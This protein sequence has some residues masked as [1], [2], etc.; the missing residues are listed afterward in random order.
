MKRSLINDMFKMI[1]KKIFIFNEKIKGVYYEY[2][3]RF[4]SLY[5]KNVLGMCGDNLV[6]YGKPI[7]FKPQ[8]IYMGDNVTLNN[9][10]T[11]SP[12]NACIYIGSNVTMSRGSQIT[13]GT[14]D[15]S[16]W[17]QENYLKREH[18]FK[19]VHIADGVWLCVNSIILPGVNIRGKGVIV[20][21]G[22]VV[23]NDID[24]DFVVVAG[25]P[26]KIVKKFK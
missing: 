15:T 19:D 21:A 24:E 25:V 18:V 6:I 14:L 22:A 11:L 8:K 3:G 10:V 17:V 9:M 4:I 16:N 1:F 7:I 13:A 20:A 23:I 5:V 12:Q 26:A 2:R